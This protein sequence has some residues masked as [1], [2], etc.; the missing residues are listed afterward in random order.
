[1]KKSLILIAMLA[2]AGCVTRNPVT[3]QMIALEVPKYTGSI[4]P[5]EAPVNLAMAPLAK[6]ATLS[7]QS[8]VS[9]VIG[10]KRNGERHQIAG[11]VDSNLIGNQI[12]ITYTIDRM[13]S[14]RGMQSLPALLIQLNYTPAGELKK[15]EIGGPLVAQAKPEERQTLAALTRNLEMAVGKFS[16]SGML[17]RSISQG[18]V[19]QAFRMDDFFRDLGVA[20]PFKNVTSSGPGFSYRLI[21]RT[22][23]KGRNSYVLHIDGNERL[24]GTDV[25]ISCVMGGYVVVDAASG[26]LSET[27]SVA[28]LTGRYLN[29]DVRVQ[30]LAKNIIEY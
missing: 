11:H 2:L 19:T 5:V 28:I 6:R 27:H 16:V 22:A 24:I 26:L 18:D 23:P 25:D 20:N 10:G 4:Q 7:A 21:G 12:Q 30:M 14:G 8:N 9:A 15:M 17:G 13:D 29:E 3:N 1:M